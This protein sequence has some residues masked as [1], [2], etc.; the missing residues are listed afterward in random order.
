MESELALALAKVHLLPGRQMLELDAVVIE[1][2]ALGKV[3]FRVEADGSYLY[4]ERGGRAVRT[5]MKGR[6]DD[7]HGSLVGF[8]KVVA[9]D[10]ERAVA[11]VTSL[12]VNA[13]P[14]T[15]S[16]PGSRITSSR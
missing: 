2:P 14:R 7:R 3:N 16:A 9:V 8:F 4:L 10:E 11:A 1:E 12:N 6:L 5:G 15:P 13:G